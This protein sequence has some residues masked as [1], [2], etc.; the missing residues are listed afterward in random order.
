MEA[1][2]DSHMAAGEYEQ[3]AVCFGLCLEQ[4]GCDP[5][6]LGTHGLRAQFCDIRSC[7]RKAL[8][9]LSLWRSGKRATAWMNLAKFSK[10]ARDAEVFLAQCPNIGEAHLVMAQVYDKSNRVAAWARTRKHSRETSVCACLSGGSGARTREGALC[11]GTHMVPTQLPVGRSM[12][13]TDNTTVDPTR[14]PKT[15]SNGK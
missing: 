13:Y 7:S 6:L 12:R 10:A 9:G 14:M 3:A 5:C 1:D 2:G 15:G 4:K 8:S 11:G